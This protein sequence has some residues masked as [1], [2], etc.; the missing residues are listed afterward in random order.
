MSI[1]NK[2]Q[3]K[4]IFSPAIPLLTVKFKIMQLDLIA[5]LQE[6]FSL[7]SEQIEILKNISTSELMSKQK[8]V[9]NP[10]LIIIGGQEGSFKE[11]L[12]KIAL[13][14]LLNNGLVLIKNNLREYHP[15][16]AEIQA[17]YP[18][19]LLHFTEDL[20]KILLSHLENQ[21]IEKRMNVMLEAS[22]G[23]TETIIQKI[24]H[25]K[26]QQYEVD[27]RILSVNKMFSFLNSEENYEL[28]LSEGNIRRNTSK[29]HHDK[30][31]EAIG[32]T[33]QKL[34]NRE[35]LDKVEV[36]Q[37]K[38]KEKD[39][40]FELKIVSLTKDKN[41]FVEAYL[42][43]R[44]R[45]FTDTELAFLKVKAQ[46]VLNMKTKR[47]ANFLEKVRFDANFK[48]ILEGKGMNGLRKEKIIK[49]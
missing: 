3:K 2:L 1:I 9:E 19:M 30:N 16:Y 27:L 14:E 38:I 25:Y 5:S 41:T 47:E 28:N 10:K 36:Y 15:N 48:L 22:L 13:K 21:A 43:E 37:F 18:D 23:N 39:H 4:S 24:N 42:Q 20:S 11:N 34:S 40:I 35:L 33:L 17:Q 32:A 26:S 29:Q 45:D 6:R 7:S 12:Q 49:N 31:Y 8:S 46:D 44:N